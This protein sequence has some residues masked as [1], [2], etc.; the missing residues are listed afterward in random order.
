MLALLALPVVLLTLGPEVGVRRVTWRDRITPSL[1]TYQGGATALFAAALEVYPASGRGLPIVSDV[2]LL[3]SISRSPRTQTRTADGGALLGNQ[4]SSWDA[5]VRYRG[6]FG[7]EELF[8]LSLRYASLRY[9]FYGA[10]LS[11]LLLPAGTLQYWRPGLDL[12]LPWG[13]LALSAG[14]GYLALVVPDQVGRA[15]PRSTQ[16]GFDAGGAVSLDLGALLGGP[17]AAHLE[18]RLSGTYRRFFYS[19]HPLPGDPYIAGGALDEYAI[20]DLALRLR[21]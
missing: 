1:T 8:A 5:G 10:G 11:G 3:G 19:L 7:D 15:F 18:L 17:V 4:W 12:R 16:R 13:R 9:D 21:G 2:G 20:F 6:V 14:A